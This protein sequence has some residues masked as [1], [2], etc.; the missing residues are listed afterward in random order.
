V[1]SDRVEPFTVAHL[2]PRNVLGT[3]FE[4][5]AVRTPL[6]TPKHDIVGLLGEGLTGIVQPGDIVFV[7]E[8]AVATSQGRAIP[9]E[10]IHPGFFAR[11][12]SRFVRKV[13]YGIGLGMPETMEMATR[14]V[15]LPRIL[16]AALV[17]MVG[18]LIGRRGD[19]YR[20]AGRQIASIDGPTPYTIPPL[21]RCVTLGPRDPD[22]IARALGR[23]LG[24]QVAVVDINDIGGVILGNTDGLDRGTVLKALADN[25]LGQGCAQT[26]VGILRPSMS[27]ALSGN[28][29]EW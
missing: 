27:I 28:V 2:E 12:L 17:A 20:I 7:S 11:L 10:D 21:N 8:K 19:F 24:V 22:R 14:A 1:N 6:I 29:E 9:L 3:R 13:P 26:P 25:P 15:G 23:R 18:R 16:L 5:L 4:R